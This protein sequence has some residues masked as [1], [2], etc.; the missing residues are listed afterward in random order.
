MNHFVSIKDFSKKD[1]L[2]LLDLASK[3]ENKE[4]TSLCQN[5]I[6]A[7]LFFEPSTRTRLSFTSAA[8]KVGSK[9]LGF[10][11]PDA[12]S[13]QKGETL[14]DTIKMVESYSDAII[15]RHPRDGSAK[16]ASDISSIP[17]I[18]A[19]DGA[20]EHPSQTL[21]DLYTIKKEFGFIDGIKIALIGD[22][23]YGRTV[24]SLAKALSLFNCEFFFIAPDNIQIPS[25]IT[26]E[27]NKNGSKYTLLNNYKEILP[28]L[29]VMYVTRIQKERF[30]DSFEYEFVKN[31]FI[32]SKDDLKGAKNNMIIM[33]PLPRVNEISID[34]DDTKHA[35]YF[36]QAKNGVVI[37]EAILAM[38]L[39]KISSSNNIEISHNLDKKIINKSNE[40]IIP[41][42]TKVCHNSKCITHGEDTD[43]K[44][45]LKDNYKTCYYCGRIVP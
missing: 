7:S 45:I 9:V 40:L 22:L 39:N 35:K 32:I 13:V 31:A 8:Y 6:V 26:M 23:K 38:A 2:N 10:D 30:E 44:I 12:T 15:I 41:F 5:N 37:R 1:I 25:Y 17:I 42:K 20:N 24:H 28:E 21:L 43:N 11:S 33:H 34:V 16:F 36:S 14:R 3:F 4:N 18:N 19:G 29:D 27:L